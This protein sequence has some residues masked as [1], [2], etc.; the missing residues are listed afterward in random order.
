SLSSGCALFCVI[1]PFLCQRACVKKTSRLGAHT[2]YSGE[3]AGVETSLGSSPYPPFHANE[4]RQRGGCGRRRG[5]QYFSV[6]DNIKAKE[7]WVR[8][9][10]RIRNLVLSLRAS[11]D[12]ILASSKVACERNSSLWGYFILPRVPSKF[13]AN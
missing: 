2:E 5:C 6:P 12:R 13:S 4:L 9:D 1:S 3:T 10:P 11:M 8:A 7:E